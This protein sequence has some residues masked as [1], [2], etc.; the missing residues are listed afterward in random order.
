LILAIAGL[1]AHEC[2]PALLPAVQAG[3]PPS[4]VAYIAMVAALDRVITV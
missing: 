4:F 2:V 3:S 1:G